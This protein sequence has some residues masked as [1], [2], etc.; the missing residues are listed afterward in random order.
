MSAL[1]DARAQKDKLWRRYQEVKEALPGIRE[2]GERRRQEYRAK[3]LLQM[4]REA[5]AEVMRLEGRQSQAKLK[6][7]IAM[8]G[9]FNTGSVVWSDLQGM[10]WGRADGMTWGDIMAA[11]EPGVATARQN[12]L[13]TQ[14]L[15]DGLAACTDR[16][17]E[18]IA[19]YYMREMAMDDIAERDGVNK[20]TVSRTI[21]RG[22]ARVAHNVVARLTIARYVTDDGLFDY[23][24]FTKE[25]SVL[26]DRQIEVMYLLL[27]HGVTLEFAGGWLGRNKSTMSRTRQRA[28]Q[29]L[30]AVRVDFI[31]RRNIK[32]V[33]FTDWINLSETE[34]AEQ[35]GLRPTFFYRYLYWGQT[36]AGFPLMTYYVMCLLREGRT[37][38]AITDQVGCSAGFVR[39]ARHQLD[40]AIMDGVTFDLSLVPPYHPKRVKRSG[41]AGNVVLAALRDLTRGEDGIIDRITPE[42]L[43]AVEQRGRACA[44][45]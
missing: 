26:T 27:T 32:G 8:D 5:C 1:E 25:T 29:R 33:K 6:R 19:A 35:L 21:K 30:E 3:T 23:V 22:L 36:I 43:E 15:N 12:R 41:R 37:A 17:R 40:P 24:E 18:Y 7:Q 39:E 42:V 4:Y 13:L 44:G 14:L 34:L 9:L 11:K 45:A 16:Q 20:S 28:E 10:T 31:P 2:T 38:E